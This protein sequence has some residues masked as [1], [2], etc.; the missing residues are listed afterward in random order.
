M[1]SLESDLLAIETYLT[2][3]VTS[4]GY[5]EAWAAFVRISKVLEE[6]KEDATIQVRT[7][8]MSN[9]TFK[10]LTGESYA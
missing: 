10:Y 8:E 1:A 6:L 4:V 2:S 5:E 3:G 7:G 9:E